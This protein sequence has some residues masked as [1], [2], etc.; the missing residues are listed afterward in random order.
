MK[1]L[2]CGSENSAS[3]KFCRGCGS[4]LNT[5]EPVAAVT[6]VPCPSCGQANVP[7]KKFCSKCGASMTVQAQLP[8]ELPQKIEIKAAPA[9]YVEEFNLCPKCNNNLKPAAK[10]CGKCGFN[11]E[12]KN[13]PQ[14][15]ESNKV[16]S[17]PIEAAATVQLSSKAASI[18]GEAIS[19]PKANTIK[20]AQAV[21]QVEHAKTDASQQVFL[22][23][24]TPPPAP[25]KAKQQSSGLVAVIGV[26]LAC[27]IGG[28]AYWWFS[29]KH[30]PPAPAADTGN[31]QAPA[32]TAS[33]APASAAADASSEPD[34]APVT[35]EAAP[36][37]PAPLPII[38]PDIPPVALPVIPPVS[39]PEAPP[40]AQ[41][42]ILPQARPVPLP[43]PTAQPVLEKPHENKKIIKLLEDARKYIAQGNYKQAEE[44]MKFCE[45]IDEGNQDCQRMKQK[46]AQLNDKMFDCV[47]AGK[48]W[49]GERCN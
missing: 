1:C 38:Q 11:F 41:P 18:A 10:F 26:L 19:P 13:T 46:A 34:A 28:G 45:M 30:A 24:A 23:D 2:K 22:K 31:M 49:V 32:D 44:S 9:V 27:A 20:A 48:E 36:P 37:A 17:K 3:A 12:Q 5:Q 6:T 14:S 29:T 47:S 33:T 39:K 16:V 4:S 43:Q 42:V 8:V 35:A 7:G 40:V 21:N 15:D 25:G